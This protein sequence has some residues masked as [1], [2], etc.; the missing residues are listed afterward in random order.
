MAGAL[1][2]IDSDAARRGAF[3][4]RLR[5]RYHKTVEFGESANALAAIRDQRPAMV[6]I[7]ADQP[8]PLGIELCRIIKTEAVDAVGAPP[9]LLVSFEGAE[10][11]RSGALDAG[12]DDILVLPRDD[13]AM[14]A[15]LR[16]IQRSQTVSEE[17]ELRRASA[18]DLGI[19]CEDGDGG[20]P[21]VLIIEP[22]GLR[23]GMDGRH[24]AALI[25]PVVSADCV[26]AHGDF[27]ALRRLEKN[28]PDA[29]I[30]AEASASAAEETGFREEARAVDLI[31]AIA[32]VDAARHAPILYLLKRAPSVTGSREAAAALDAGALDCA[33][34]DPA[35]EE[36]SLRLRGHLARKRDADRL[37]RVVD[38]GLRQA[39]R[40]SLTHLHNRRYLD[41]H[42]Q[43]RLSRSREISAPL[44]V[45]IFDI[46]DFKSI[47]DRLG[48]AGGD[49]A[50]RRFASLL[51]DEVR[52][53]DLVARYG[54]D[55]FVVVM[56][57]T[58]EAQAAAAS[59][60]L[61]RRIA[62][63]MPSH[64]GLTACVGIAEAG[65][66]DARAEDVFDRAD[67]ALRAA[68]KARKARREQA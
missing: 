12:A 65:E 21:Q 60:R 54:G 49:E 59:D 39:I 13:E 1:F 30:V 22:N 28:P 34:L 55:E 50:L 66:A 31:R 43:R 58:T 62:Q 23:D 9:V 18:L 29:V 25:E 20:R 17:L 32:A 15:R 47:N 14:L 57:D 46:D 45:L 26:V 44:S 68:K 56:S 7:A 19:E 38:E 33:Y 3:A 61:R 35:G 67:A 8:A 41:A 53:A 10:I 24:L 51:S 4:E 64:F 2:I 37:R 6:L 40:D 52:A 11:A 16:S 5:R 63:E 27:D 48:L 42:F 36:L